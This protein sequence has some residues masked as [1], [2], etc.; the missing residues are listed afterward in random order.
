MCRDQ[1][2]GRISDHVK[3]K[4]GAVSAVSEYC[5]LDLFSGDAVR[6]QH[7][8]RAMFE[9]PQNNLKLFQDGVLMFT[10][11]LG[12]GT[13]NNAHQSAG[14]LSVDSLTSILV[15]ILQKE[16][17]LLDNLRMAQQLDSL[18]IEAIHYLYCKL[19]QIPNI[20]P[21]DLSRF[22]DLD[23]LTNEQ[24]EQEI[25]KYLI[26]TTAKDCSIMATFLDTNPLASYRVGVVDL[27]P[28]RRSS[29]PSKE[30]KKIVQNVQ[31]FVRVRPQSQL[32]LL[33]KEPLPLNCVTDH[34]IA[35][36]YKGSVRTYQFD[37]VFPSYS[38]QEDLFNV[39][40][41]PI[42]DE[43]LNGFNGTI[44]VYGQTATGKTYTMEGVMDSPEDCGIIP[45]TIAYIFQ[46]L[47]KA[48]SDY[49]VRV[50]HL[51]I[52]KEEIFDLLA[53]DDAYKALN[54][55]DTKKVPSV[56]D[57][58]EIVVN[59]TQS[60]M[61]ILA[62]SCRKRQTAETMYNKQSSRSHCI[63]T[64]TIHIKETTIGGEDLIKIGKLNLVDL[65][66]SEG[67]QKSGTNERMREAAVINQS[68]LTLG[69]VITALTTDANGHIPYRDSKLTRLLQDSLGGKTKTSIIATV[70][71]SALNIEETVNTLDYALKAKSIRNTPQI[72]QK[73]S[74]SS[75]LK[76][77]SAE[78]GRLKQLLQ[79]AYDKNGVY[80]TMEE[81]NKNVSKAEE[82]AA[83]ILGFEIQS[84]NDTRQIAY[85][86]NALSTS[87]AKLKS[88]DIEYRRMK[89][90][91]Q[92]KTEKLAAIQADDVALRSTVDTAVQDISGLH[93]KLGIFN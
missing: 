17:S 69:R 83:Q 3:V 92:E 37:H 88:N 45:R 75:L 55:Y 72:N 30:D 2:E 65:A 53:I 68:L 66:G 25:N 80:L 40:V 76:E 52:Y 93:F 71:P 18:D 28:K 16:R 9:C 26:A 11:A 10:G 22:S 81:H 46:T 32:E 31:V 24:M 14:I 7:A 91:V 4:E 54:V 47:E 48:G 41:K 61:A 60:I 77:Q 8:I 58:E 29:I 56:P 89:Q 33:T 64:I 35:C 90:E 74:K 57:L 59:D 20:D 82:Q 86:K 38:R 5:P 84:H 39:S 43:V 87:D 67:F 13:D 34:E 15:G 1:A 79:A 49:N 70:S 6:Q 50:S 23:N 51:E 85:L 19:E 73:M 63:F 62:K 12:G 21:S 78:I 42:A 27:D 44:F 36:N